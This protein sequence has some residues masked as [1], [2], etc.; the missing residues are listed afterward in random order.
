M[1]TVLHWYRYPSPGA[2]SIEQ[3][4]YTIADNI[5]ALG[6]DTTVEKRQVPYAGGALLHIIRNILYAKKHQ[7]LVNHITGDIHYILLGLHS[8]HYNILTIH[9]CGFMHRYPKWSPKYWV[10]KWLWLTWPVKK[11]DRITVISTKTRDEVIQFTRC[12]AH[13]IVL[14]PNFVKPQ[15]Q[16]SPYIFN[17]ECPKILHIGITPN[18]NLERLI[19]AMEG[20]PC[21][22]E[23]IG[24][25]TETHLELLDHCSVQWTAYQDLS[26]E[27]VAMRYKDADMIVFA[28]T[29]E[30]FGMPIIEA[31]ATGRP[32]VTSNLE[33]MTSVAG[34]HGACFVDPLD[35][36]AIRAGILSVIHDE[37]YR[38]DLI[39][40]G[41]ENI[42]RFDVDQVTKQ[43]LAIYQHPCAASQA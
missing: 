41:L 2:Y 18:K 7:G 9:D 15:F 3:L 11:A 29:F 28:S 31:Q 23:I 13:K 4:F 39:T 32:V 30:G 12:P 24:R 17:Q 34:P 21:Q 33:P 16:Y 35:I 27:E 26:M 10:L 20:L 38:N 8:S 40:N 36:L 37:K 19:R 43:Y 5:N 1:T 22:L 6:V 42:K 25:P 14:I